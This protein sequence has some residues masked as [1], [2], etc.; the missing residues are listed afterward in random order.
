MEILLY[1][2]FIIILKRVR[3]DQIN[4]ANAVNFTLYLMTNFDFS[5]KYAI[6]INLVSITS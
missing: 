3:K 6:L 1:H 4:L 2:T 5:N